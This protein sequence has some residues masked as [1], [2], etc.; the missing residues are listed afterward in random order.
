MG[1]TP[2]P[3]RDVA[4]HDNTPTYRNEPAKAN[5]ALNQNSK[6]LPNMASSAGLPI[7]TTKTWT[8]SNSSYLSKYDFLTSPGSCPA[9]SK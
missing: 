7:L 8:N 6:A 4:V 9:L 5:I 3:E 2:G 1:L